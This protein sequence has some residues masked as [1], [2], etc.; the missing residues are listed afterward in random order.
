M[1]DWQV[2]LN[3]FVTCIISLI[4]TMIF[5]YVVNG[6]KKIRKEKEEKSLDLIRNIVKEEL[7]EIA[8]NSNLNRKGLQELLKSQLKSSYDEWLKKGYAPTNI[9]EDLERMY[10]VYHSLGA[11]GVMDAHREKFLSLPISKESNKK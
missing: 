5:N 3:A 9:K 10:K 7:E 8:K 1:L 11:N 2:C 4:A 6:T